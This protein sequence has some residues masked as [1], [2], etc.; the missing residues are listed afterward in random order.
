LPIAQR[1]A[2]MT[3]E[4]RLH[5]RELRRDQP[6][7][8]RR[9]R[10]ACRAP[11]VAVD[12]HL[13]L[14]DDAGKFGSGFVHLTSDA[15]ALLGLQK[16]TLDEESEQLEDAGVDHARAASNRSNASHSEARRSLAGRN[17][18][19]TTGIVAARCAY[20]VTNAARRSVVSGSHGCACMSTLVSA[21][22]P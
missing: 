16:V 22:A 14:V 8:R 20:R 21:A 19:R 11:I 10:H 4:A 13:A 18:T 1:H 7:R 2:E 17:R 9:H 3:L 12:D 6:R 15:R 5:R